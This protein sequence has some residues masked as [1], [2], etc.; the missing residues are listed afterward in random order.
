MTC[1]YVVTPNSHVPG[2]PRPAS[3]EAPL[4]TLAGSVASSAMKQ[5]RLALSV[6]RY[7]RSF[8]SL[9]YSQKGRSTRRVCDGYASSSPPKESQAIV[10]KSPT[11]AHSPPG[12]QLGQFEGRMFHMFRNETVKHVAGVFDHSFWKV[13]VLRAARIYPAIWHASLAVAAMQERNIIHAGTTNLDIKR[14]FYGFALLQYN[15][16]IRILLEIATKPNLSVADQETLLMASM[17]FTTLSILQSDG[18]QAITHANNGI[19]LFYRWRYWE[20]AEQARRTGD[21]ILSPDFFATIV[22]VATS[23]FHYDRSNFSPWSLRN[24]SKEAPSAVAFE[25][26]SDAFTALEPLLTGMM[27][28][29]NGLNPDTDEKQ[30]LH[31]IREKQRAYR[32]DF[33]AWKCKFEMLKEFKIL[34]AED[35]WAIVQIKALS[36][37]MQI[38]LDLNLDDMDME[39]DAF[40]PSFEQ[41]VTLTEQLLQTEDQGPQQWGYSFS[42]SISMLLFFVS[43]SCRDSKLRRRAIDLLRDIPDRTSYIYS[44]LT[45][46]LCESIMEAEE[47]GLLLAA[48]DEGCSCVP[49]SFICR[50]HRAVFRD[51]QVVGFGEI[52]VSIRTVAD[53]KKDRPGKVAPLSFS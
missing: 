40:Y 25:T 22:A 3:H 16:A 28:I 42:H 44:K 35:S 43:T 47:S 51:T 19:Q 33:A 24:L 31:L 20:Q 15:A 46:K 6:S 48:D 23:Q 8:Y 12:V 17:L 4:T 18:S 32:E 14:K 41:I 5:D 39:F 13:N 50:E 30:Q 45:A 29:L 53:L 10:T 37:G 38:A 1:R 11:Y 36:I 2:H 21:R 9:A 27:E 7:S 26:A 34:S 49:N 52:V